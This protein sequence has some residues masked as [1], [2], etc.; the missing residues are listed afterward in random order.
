[1]KK[2]VINKIEKFV[3][4]LPIIFPV[5]MILLIYLD[6]FVHDFDPW[7]GEQGL[8]TIGIIFSSVFVGVIASIVITY[9]LKTIRRRSD[10]K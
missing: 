1:M 2:S 9:I 8:G 6:A 5:G 4:F 10:K 7:Y 3:Y